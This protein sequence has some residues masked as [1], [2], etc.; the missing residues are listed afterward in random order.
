MT[1]RW[2]AMDS[3]GVATH[4]RYVFDFLAVRTAD[5]VRLA[6]PLDHHTRQW[7]RKQVGAITYIVSPVHAFDEVEARQQSA[8]VERL[9]RF[10]GVPAF[11]ITFYSCTDPTE[12]FRIRGYQYHPL[13]HIHATG[14]R[15]EGDDLVF[16]GN[17]KD[18]YTHEIVHLFTARKFTDR[19]WVLDEGLATVLAGSSE[20]PFVRH[21]ANLKRYLTA[22]PSL[23]LAEVCTSYEPHYID[24]DTNVAYAI[25]GVLCERILRSQGKAALF[26]VMSSGADDLFTAL[27]DHGITRANLRDELLKELAQEPLQ[28]D[29]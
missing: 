19:P 6:F 5:G 18:L 13:M 26:A 17:D 11:P 22:D 14:G 23:D 3:A 8:E 16:S 1:V 25:G 12:L 27:A 15:A 4:V 28:V 20:R 29:W 2:A 9:A 7:E 21:R 24:R 10:F